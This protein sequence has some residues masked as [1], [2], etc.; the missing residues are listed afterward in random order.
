MNISG[1][2]CIINLIVNT[3]ERKDSVSA[4]GVVHYTINGCV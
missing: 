1:L 3:S 2:G 4:R